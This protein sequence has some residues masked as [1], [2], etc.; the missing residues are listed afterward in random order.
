[1]LFEEVARVLDGLDTARVR[2]WV[3]GGWGVAVLA[4]RQTRVQRD[5]DV[6]ID[7]AELDMCL[8]ALNDLGY[9]VETG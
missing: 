1:V 5:L 9:V 6:A 3:A 8:S 4:G 7:A 2:Y